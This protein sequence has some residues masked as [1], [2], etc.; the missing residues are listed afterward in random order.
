M[1]DGT[2]NTMRDAMVGHWVRTSIASNGVEV[3]LN[4]LG[5][6]RLSKGIGDPGITVPVEDVRLILEVYCRPTPGEPTT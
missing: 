4:S 2:W 5:D 1:S 6:L 3:S